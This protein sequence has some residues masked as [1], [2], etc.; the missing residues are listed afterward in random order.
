M[1]RET[2]GRVVRQAWV[3]Y[4]QEIGDT[5]PSHLAPW[6]E[7]SEQD[8]EADRRIGEAVVKAYLEARQSFKVIELAQT[9]ASNPSQWEGVLADGR[10][11]YVRYRWSTL[12]VQITNSDN[13]WVTI[14]QRGGG[15]GYDGLMDTS[16]MIV[17]LSEVL[18]F[19]EVQ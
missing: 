5:K 17:E 9:C 13:D 10:R 15:T 7:L 4:C 3:E 14:Y 2:L 1:D 18:D 8:K 16:E 12:T 11:L 6:E 19:S